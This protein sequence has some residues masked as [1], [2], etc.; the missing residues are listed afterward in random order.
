MIQVM[1]QHGFDN[2]LQHDYNFLK[3]EDKH[4]LYYSCNRDW[5]EGLRGELCAEAKERENDIKFKIGETKFVLDYSEAEQL[6]I[7]LLH[8]NKDK[9]EIRE[10]KVIKSI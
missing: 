7:L 9:I 4:F 1:T 6:L 5:I 3:L 10:S 8:L 2:E